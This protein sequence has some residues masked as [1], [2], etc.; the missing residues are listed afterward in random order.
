MTEQKNGGFPAYSLNVGSNFSF[1]LS[2]ISRLL[3]I[4]SLC[5]RLSTIMPTCG[6][7]ALWNADWEIPER[8]ENGSLV[9]QILVFFA[10]QSAA[11]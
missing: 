2:H 1:P 6:F 8:K 5:L 10:G 3:L 11:V 4:L 7:H 9:L